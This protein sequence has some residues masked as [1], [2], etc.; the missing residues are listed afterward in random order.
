M[1]LAEINLNKNSIDCFYCGSNIA[2]GDGKFVALC[3]AEGTI[4]IKRANGS[5]APMVYCSSDCLV[6]DCKLRYDDRLRRGSFR[7]QFD[8]LFQD[9]YPVNWKS[10]AVEII[11]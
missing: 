2:S 7:K 11:K 6:Y 9:R 4:T 3:T 8:Q 10:S 5:P 1:T